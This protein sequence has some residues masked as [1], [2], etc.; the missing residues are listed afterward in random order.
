MPYGDH[1]II[2]ASHVNEYLRI[3]NCVIGC[4]TCKAIHGFRIE[5]KILVQSTMMDLVLKEFETWKADWPESCSESADI[6]HVSEVMG[7]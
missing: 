1:S 3:L 2:F 4:E 5:E 7:T 6:V